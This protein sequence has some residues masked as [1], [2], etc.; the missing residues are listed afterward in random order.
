M[1]KVHA[2]LAQSFTYGVSRVTKYMYKVYIDIYKLYD[3]V[4]SLVA[5]CLCTAY[6]RNSHA[7]YIVFSIKYI[8]FLLLHNP[9]PLIPLYLVDS[10]KPPTTIAPNSEKTTFTIYAPYAQSLYSAPA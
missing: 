5:L 7:R 10:T 1:M 8:F 9:S 2:A 4:R 3:A 6:T